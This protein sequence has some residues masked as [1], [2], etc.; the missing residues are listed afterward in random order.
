M[1]KEGN[2]KKECKVANNA[3]IANFVRLWITLI[4]QWE[5]KMG[6]A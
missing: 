4:D 5:L 1:N 3:N 6:F 2:S